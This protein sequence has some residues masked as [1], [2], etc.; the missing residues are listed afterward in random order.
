M[1]HHKE[2]DRF[3]EAQNAKY[4]GSYASALKEIQQGRKTTHW[5]WYVFPQLECLGHSS[6]ALYYGITDRQE[7]TQYL[8]HPTL[9]GRLRE[10][11]EA[12]L[13]HKA[14]AAHD[15]LGDIDAMKVRS[16]MTLFDAI[17]PN[18]IFEQVLATFYGGERCERTLHFLQKQ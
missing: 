18:D 14:K 6:T 5:I 3:I 17:A 9:G 8:N 2:L 12:L 1:L 15:I 16:C 11:S 13:Q 7:A 4:Y 10:I